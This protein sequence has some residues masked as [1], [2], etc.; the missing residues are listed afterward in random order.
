M[1]R[2][3][4]LT[5]LA[6]ADSG[7]TLPILDVSATTTKKITKT[8]FL[9]DIV[10]GTLMA[11]QSIT[12]TKVDLS[13]ANDAARTALTG[14]EGLTVYQEDT[15]AFYIYDGS[16]WRR[17]AQWE[18]LGRTTLSSTAD[19]IS[20]AGFAARKYLQIHI[21][22]IPSG[23]LNVGIR[24]N[25]DTG[26]NYAYRFEA[27][28]AAQT[29]TVSTSSGVFSSTGAFNNYAVLDINN[30]TS[31]A[32]IAIGRSS[33]Y[34][35]SAAAAP[36]EAFSWVKWANLVSQIT[37]ADVFNVGAGDFAIGSQVIVLGR[38]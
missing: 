3:S 30:N 14:F 11:A 35:D 19:S 2:I 32:K 15:D 24:F 12:P 31:I 7:D 34:S 26:N 17:Q 28:N 18:E 4:N 5:A 27:D 13:V 10:N 1:T 22:L 16:A 37:R 8:A 21:L 36:S 29:T 23:A 38:D 33:I 9:S 6:S 20:V 25:N